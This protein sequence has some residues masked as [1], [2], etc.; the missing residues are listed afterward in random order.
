[1]VIESWHRESS[2]HNPEVSL[3]I[4]V[5]EMTRSVSI[6]DV[7]QIT[8]PQHGTV[9]RAHHETMHTLVQRVFVA[10]AWP[11]AWWVVLFPEATPAQEPEPI[12]TTVSNVWLPQLCVLFNWCLL[13]LV[14][15]INNICLVLPELTV[16][17]HQ[18]QWQH[19]N[20]AS[21]SC[22]TLVFEWSI[23]KVLRWNVWTLSL[24]VTLFLV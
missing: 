8:D 15:D 24:A 2:R 3:V 7:M 22:I 6:T 5:P 13:Q 11:P 4:T 1:M 9:N 23:L 21:Q 10:P 16:F 12:S 18:F 14:M 19:F 17:L 20:V